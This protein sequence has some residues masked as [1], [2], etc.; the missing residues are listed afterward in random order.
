MWM[1]NNIQ[2]FWEEIKVTASRKSCKINNVNGWTTD[3]GYRMSSS[4]Y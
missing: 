2:D 4:T 1:E 3:E